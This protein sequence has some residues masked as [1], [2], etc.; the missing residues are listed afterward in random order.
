MTS[1]ESE[2]LSVSI[3]QLGIV[4]SGIDE[5]VLL[6]AIEQISNEANRYEALGILDG[7]PKYFLKNASNFARVKRLAAIANLF[8]VYKM[9]ESDVRAGADL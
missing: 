1:E 2:S 3:V 8:C 6:D 7:N 9:T 4:L 5:N